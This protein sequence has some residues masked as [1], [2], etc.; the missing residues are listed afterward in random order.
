MLSLN[1]Q[2]EHPSPQ[3][4]EPSGSSDLYGH[5]IQSLRERLA[6]GS[7]EKSELESQSGLVKKQFDTW[8][9]RAVEEKVVKESK[10]VVLYSLNQQPEHISPQEPSGSSDLYG[11]FIQSLREQLEIGSLQKSELKNQS[12]LVN[13]QFDAWMNRAI[14]EKVVKKKSKPVV[15]YSLNRTRPNCIGKVRGRSSTP[16]IRAQNKKGGHLDVQ[17]WPPSHCTAPNP[18]LPEPCVRHLE[19][20]CKSHFSPRHYIAAVEHVAFGEN[21]NIVGRTDRIGRGVNNEAGPGRIGFAQAIFYNKCFEAATDFCGNA[22]VL[23]AGECHLAQ[24]SLYEFVAI[25]IVR[26]RQQLIGGHLGNRLCGHN[27]SFAIRVGFDN[28]A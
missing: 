27:R 28:K 4:Q 3:E 10:P 12:G 7:I 25:A 17:R 26:H 24:F 8:M 13:S 9:K 21:T 11:H 6:N 1:Q 18:E 20:V 16:F 2:P 15:S 14:E 22:S 5:F 23:P 19:Y